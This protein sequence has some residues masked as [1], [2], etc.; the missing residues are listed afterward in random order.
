MNFKYFITVIGLLC[1]ANMNA[2][3]GNFNRYYVS[4]S[5]SVGLGQKAYADSSAWLQVGADSSTKG[6]ILPRVLLDSINTDER[7][8]FV[9][10][11]EDSVLYHFDDTTKVRYMTYRDTTLI[12]QVALGGGLPEDLIVDGG[13]SKG[14]AISI[15][16]NDAQDVIIETNGAERMKVSENKTTFETLVGI[17]QS[18]PSAQLHITTD[19]SGIRVGNTGNDIGKFYSI[20]RGYSAFHPVSYFDIGLLNYRTQFKSGS[21]IEFFINS[22]ASRV[23]SLNAA[24]PSA[25]PVELNTLA[26]SQA[27]DLKGG[28]LGDGWDLYVPNGLFTYQHTAFPFKFLGFSSSSSNPDIDFHVRPKSNVLKLFGTSGNV[29]INTTTDVGK[30]FTVEGDSRF[31]GSNDYYVDLGNSMQV[32][33][34]SNGNRIYQLSSNGDYS[35]RLDLF[36]A[37]DVVKIQLSNNGS[38]HAPNLAVGKASVGAHTLTV[39]D[40]KLGINGSTGRIE[41]YN[42][43]TPATNTIMIGDGSDFKTKTLYIE[44]TSTLDFS[45]TS[46]NSYSDLNVTVTGA[47]DGDP[48]SIGVPGGSVLSNTSFFAWVSAANTVTVRLINNDNSSAKDPASGSF[49]IKVF[50]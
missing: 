40:N 18:T 1:A 12:K 15:G 38:Y 3:P 21:G 2:Q 13:N 10:D 41:K 8:L 24:A 42:N 16:T 34:E 20:L 31:Y 37:N 17:G 49:K 29:G 27:V 45:S 30:Q 7:G 32:Y 26:G 39:G 22:A 48:V 33:R 43:A 9:Y 23:L 11:L 46:A 35:A 50:K 6:V 28:I 5:L 14:A 4:G 19:T 25:G 44:S 47:A 36:D